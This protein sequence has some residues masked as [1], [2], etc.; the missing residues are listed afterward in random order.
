MNGWLIGPLLIIYKV[1]IHALVD[2]FTWHAHS[3][4]HVYVP[5]IDVPADWPLNTNNPLTDSYMS[6]Y[7]L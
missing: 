2:H 4:L 6:M 1:P 3:F 5:A 7:L